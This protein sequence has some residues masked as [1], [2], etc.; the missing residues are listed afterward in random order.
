MKLFFLTD[1]SGVNYINHNRSLANVKIQWAKD[2]STGHNAHWF[3]MT[4]NDMN[5]I[6][7]ANLALDYVAT[8]DI[9]EDE[10]I[11]LDY[12]DDWEKAWQQHVANWEPLDHWKDYVSGT[13]FNKI[14]ATDPVR[15]QMEQIENPYLENLDIRC[16]QF[17]LEDEHADRPTMEYD[18]ELEWDL[19]FDK[20][21]PC[22]ILE[23]DDEEQTYTVRVRHKAFGT[24]R[25]DVVEEVSRQAIVFLDL[26]YSTDIHLVRAFRHP[27]GIPDNMMPEAWKNIMPENGND[28]L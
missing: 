19:P 15:T 4:P 25:I 26:P 17:I 8:K 13:Q 21:W 24:P 20:G 3:N 11:F 1:G 6:Y 7:Q 2:G 27:L 5:F 22:E 12:G 16:H 23:R 10:E 9:A 28:E 14:Y 18:P